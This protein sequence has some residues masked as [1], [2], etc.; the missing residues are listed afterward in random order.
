VGTGGSAGKSGSLEEGI[1]S[2]KGAGGGSGWSRKPQSP[3]LGHSLSQPHGGHGSTSGQPG[4]THKKSAG[5]VGTPVADE[6]TRVEAEA[7]VVSK[8][9]S[10][11]TSTLVAM[12]M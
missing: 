12:A 11:L 8:T 6:E 7:E 4:P 5:P 1:G 10:I 9:D 2:S 3:W